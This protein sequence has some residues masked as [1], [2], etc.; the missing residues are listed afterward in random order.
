[1]QTQK[2]KYANVKSVF[3]F[4]IPLTDH[5]FTVESLLAVATRSPSAWKVAA[6]MGAVCPFQ[7]LTKV[8]CELSSGTSQRRIS[9]LSLAVITLFPS[10]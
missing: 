5:T 10:G 1:M 6:L 2:N 4:A 9:W 3:F 8:A 7:S